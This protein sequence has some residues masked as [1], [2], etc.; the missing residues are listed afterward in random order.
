M[1]AICCDGGSNMGNLDVQ[2]WTAIHVASLFH[3][4]MAGDFRRWYL[5]FANERRG[6]LALLR[7]RYHQINGI[8]TQ[9]MCYSEEMGGKLK[10]E[11][12]VLGKK[13]NHNFIILV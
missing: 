8:Q 10:S 12:I 1:D 4:V 11:K 13:I 5:A 6:N 2:D 9:V 7:Y 3:I